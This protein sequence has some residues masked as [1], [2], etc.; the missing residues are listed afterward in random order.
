MQ[1]AEIAKYASLHGNK[2]AI[3]HFA[4]V[5]GT[6]IKES[7]VCTWK[8]KYLTEI[9]RKVSLGETTEGGVVVNS[10]PVKKRGRPLLLGDKLDSDVKSYVL[11]V[12]EAAHTGNNHTYILVQDLVGRK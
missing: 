5:L 4:K 6:E 7:S 1:Q 10:L 9:K 3:R 8:S 11:A 12:R 2:A